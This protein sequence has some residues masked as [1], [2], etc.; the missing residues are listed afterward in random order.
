MAFSF[1]LLYGVP[2]GALPCKTLQTGPKSI[3]VATSF[4]PTRKSQGTGDRNQLSASL[5]KRMIATALN[6]TKQFLELGTQ[7]S[8]FK[9]PNSSFSWNASKVAMASHPVPPMEVCEF[10]HVRFSSKSMQKHH[11]NRPDDDK[12][13]GGMLPSGSHVVGEDRIGSL[14]CYEICS[15]CQ[16]LMDKIVFLSIQLVLG[17]SVQQQYYCTYKWASYSTF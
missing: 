16:L 4:P 15:S 6:I 12:S 13:A 3:V 10:V 14:S 2:N 1:S 9:F 11:V 7:L 17:W 5:F 8:I